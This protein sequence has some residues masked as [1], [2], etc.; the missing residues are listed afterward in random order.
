[1]KVTNDV[2]TLY[3]RIKEPRSVKKGTVSGSA[4][5]RSTEL[6]R[7]AMDVCQNAKSIRNLEGVHVV[8]SGELR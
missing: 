2:E 7:L 5:S 3:R 6:E 1:M 4:D 8:T